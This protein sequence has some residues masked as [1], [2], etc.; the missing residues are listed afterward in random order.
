MQTLRQFMVILM[1]LVLALPALGHSA[2]GADCHGASH[3]TQTDMVHKH[4]PTPGDLCCLAA[5]CQ[6]CAP[7]QAGTTF[8]FAPCLVAS[9]FAVGRGEAGPTASPEPADQPPRQSDPST[10]D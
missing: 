2:V 1:V 3:T 6:I 8:A 9:H 4:M 5:S 7:G 10:P